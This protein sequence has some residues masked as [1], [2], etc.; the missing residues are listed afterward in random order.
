M[1]VTIHHSGIVIP[2]TQN[3]KCTDVGVLYLLSCTKAFCRKQYIGETGRPVYLWFKDHL[4]S[5]EDPLTTT[6]VG[7]HFQSPG[8][9]KADMELV[10]F[11]KVYGDSATRKQRERHFINIYNLITHG[12][13]KKL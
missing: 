1:Q 12:L 10:P 7:Q 5:A 2:I 4:D 13:N 3:I 9:T 6:P 8:H 11:E